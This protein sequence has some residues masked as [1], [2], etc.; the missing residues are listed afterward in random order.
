M[1]SARSCICHAGSCASAFTAGRSWPAWWGKS[2]FIYD[3][4]GDAVNIAARLEAAGG[5]GRINVSETVYHHLRSLMESEA[6]GAVEV[7]NKA[8]ITMYFLTRIK[9]EFSRDA[10]GLRPNEA[11]HRECERLFPG[12]RAAA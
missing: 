10:E 2:K 7:K 5:V 3:V 12:Y 6:R 8:P 9:A 4:W 1:A 11:F